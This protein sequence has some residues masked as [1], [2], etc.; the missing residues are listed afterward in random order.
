MSIIEP[1]EHV[2]T[3]E[4]LSPLPV[5]FPH[6][7]IPLPILVRVSG[8]Y[9]ATSHAFPVLP[10]SP[11]EDGASTEDFTP[12][13]EPIPEPIPT[14]FPQPRLPWKP[15]R[16]PRIPRIPRVPITEELRLDVDGFYPQMVASGVVRR[17]LSDRIEWIAELEQTGSD[18]WA[19]PIVW[20]EGTT[21]LLPHSHV[22]V[23]A[24]RSWSP[25]GRK[26]VVT[27]SGGATT[28]TRV[29]GFKSAYFHQ[30][31]L[32]FDCVQGV[33]LV[34][35]IDTHA[36][37][38]R[39]ASLPSETLS[40]EKVFQ[41]AGFDTRASGG[42]TT[43]PISAAGAD[44][45][46][47]DQEMHDA[48]QVHWSR[49]KDAP[50][51][52]LWTLF[53]NQHIRGHGL[54]GIMFD[55]IGPN[56]RQG[57]ALFID[58]FISDVPSGEAN[59]DAYKRRMRFWTAVHEMGHAFNLAHSW[60]KHLGNPWR[61]LSS[62]PEA[63]SFMNYPFKVSGGQSAFFADFEY[64]FSDG[65]LLFLRHAPERFVQQGNADWFDDHGFEQARQTLAS[66]LELIVR[67]NRAQDEYEFLEPVTIELKLKNTSGQPVIF[68]A[69]RLATTDEMTIIVKRSGEAARMFRPFARYC[70]EPRPAVLQPGESLY[71]SLFVS[72]GLTGW[73]I[74]EPGDYLVQIALH[75]DDAD[76]VSQPMTLRVTPPR[77]YDEEY[78]AQKLFTEEVGRVL[79]FEGSR[80]LTGATDTLGE[81]AERLSE[82]R[83]ARH[84]RYVLGAPRAKAR[85]KL[86]IRGEAAEDARIVGAK[87]ETKAAVED[88]KKALTDDMDEAATTFGHIEYKRRVDFLTKV[89]ED[90]G[91]SQDAA[92]VQRELHDVLQQRG[93][94]ERVLNEVEARAESLRS[95]AS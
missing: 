91:E 64:R 76:V 72:A 4:E 27:F 18:T 93:V 43:I 70:L 40:I 11:V 46:W 55:D 24:T 30:V 49:F 48:M 7:P 21:S 82:R 38:N 25:S 66:D 8:L 65:E 13:P 3:A 84:A 94:L 39:P 87:A 29:F 51:W 2:G 85:K 89:L 12:G 62:E 74:S 71:E 15:P 14:P 75:L 73:G 36:H 60:Q 23:K 80:E 44:S 90:E 28:R 10:V 45:K 69:S 59:P 78:L 17:F 61:P 50:Q 57:T 20:K 34:K 68:D 47:T 77:G 63:R 56:H 95:K 83:I 88:L 54:G 81:A 53:A 79:A 86:E 41:R 37:P 19:G 6:Q 32:E 33:S 67:A 58:S 52:S 35:D 92:Q 9:T 31:E 42:D 22:S 26:A 16:I 1:S 5:P